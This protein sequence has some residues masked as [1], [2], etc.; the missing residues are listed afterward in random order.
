[1]LNERVPRDFLVVLALGELLGTVTVSDFPWPSELSK[2]RTPWLG[3]VM[4]L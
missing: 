4:D 3:P 1:M 2:A